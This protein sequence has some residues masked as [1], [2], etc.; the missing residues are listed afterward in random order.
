MQN[1]HQCSKSMYVTIQFKLIILVLIFLFLQGLC[2]LLCFST[3][4]FAS[5][6]RRAGE[7]HLF[8]LSEGV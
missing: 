5:G 2:V 8:D 1:L 7:V 3:C 4:A 6:G